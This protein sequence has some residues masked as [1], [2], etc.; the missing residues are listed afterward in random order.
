MPYG[1]VEFHSVL[2][3]VPG[4]DGIA[5]LYVSTMDA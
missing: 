4:L 5:M 2:L 1:R 3:S